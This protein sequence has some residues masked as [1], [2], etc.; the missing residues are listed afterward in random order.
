MKEFNV[1]Q[2]SLAKRVVNENKGR[3]FYKNA[4]TDCILI[5]NVP[6][7]FTCN[8]DD[9]LTIFKNYSILVKKGIIKK[10]LPSSEFNP[11][12][13]DLV[14]NAGKKGGV[15]ITPG[16]VNTH[17]HPPMY[18]MRSIMTLEEGEGLKDTIE[19]MPKWERLMNDEDIAVGS[20][21]DITEQQRYGITSTLSHYGVFEPIDFAASLTRHN[22]INALSAVS[23]THPENSPEMIEDLLKRKKTYS[24]P[25]VALHYLY[26]AD[27]KT[28]GKIRDLVRKH[29]ILFTCH[30]AESEDVAQECQ[31]KRK[32][33]E[34]TLLARHGLL[35]K[36]SI[37]SHSIALKDHE[38]KRIV[39]AGA[40]ISHLPTSNTIHKSGRFPFWKFYDYGGFPRI[41]LGTD[42]VVSKCRVDVLSEAYQ[43]RITHIYERSVKFG[44]L[45]KMATANGARILGFDNR[46]KILPGYNADLAIWKLNDISCIPFDENNPITLISNLITHGG[47]P[48][49]D[50][51]INGEFIIKN[52]QHQ[53]VN[54]SSL[55]RNMQKSHMQMRKRVSD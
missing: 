1:L 32:A 5:H 8:N 29:S 53:F 2:K 39:E 43:T 51:M 24:K 45:F 47:R 40:G 42:G 52:R 35:N 34:V 26:K 28:L 31:R 16:L 11:D 37:L 18:L 55:L 10:L 12:D 46:G 13:F 30:M 33:R 41:A 21:G 23:N 19:A 54:E 9:K 49:R 15:V 36:N 4:A 38:I 25:G 48:V 20:L 44:S 17:A 50:L 27:D 6:Y 3:Y 14:Y 7:I 22:L